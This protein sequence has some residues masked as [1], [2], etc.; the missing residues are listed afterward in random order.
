[1]VLFFEFATNVPVL[2][3]GQNLCATLESFMRCSH[4]NAS[5]QVS[6]VLNESEVEQFAEIS[7]AVR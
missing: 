5:G 1:M 2:E 4:S 7:W 3:F 6:P